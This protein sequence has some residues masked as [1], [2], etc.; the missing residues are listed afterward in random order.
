MKS[1]DRSGGNLMYAM[2]AR[3]ALLM[4]LG[5]AFLGVSGTAAA[6]NDPDRR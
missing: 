2:N 6:D 4:I 5:A 3:K 1:P